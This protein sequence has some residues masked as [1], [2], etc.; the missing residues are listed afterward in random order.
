VTDGVT[1]FA[2]RLLTYSLQAEVENRRLRQAFNFSFLTCANFV[3]QLSSDQRIKF[4]SFI[5]IRK[6]KER[7]N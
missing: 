2:P 3:G 1:G 5:S 6:Q 7:K 4:Y